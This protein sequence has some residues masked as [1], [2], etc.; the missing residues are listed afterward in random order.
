MTLSLNRI[1]SI[2]IADAT[3]IRLNALLR[4]TFPATT[5]DLAGA[6]LHVVHN[7]TDATIDY[8]DIID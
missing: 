3:I 7:I 5:E 2:V 8:L 6:K 1:H 4:E